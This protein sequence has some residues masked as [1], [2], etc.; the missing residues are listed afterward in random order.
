M[1]Q[2]C[3]GHYGAQRRVPQRA[4]D[5]IAYAELGRRFR[6]QRHAAAGG[7]QRHHGVDVRR[8]L[9]NAHGEARFDAGGHDLIV[10]GRDHAPRD[11]HERLDEK[12]PS[13]TARAAASR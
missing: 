11:Q 2:V 3:D 5:D 10:D 7:D 12:S 9:R 1:P 13:D 6:Q 4:A 8:F